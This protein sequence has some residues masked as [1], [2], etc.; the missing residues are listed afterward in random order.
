[1]HQLLP[2]S[3]EDTFES[4]ICDLFNELYNTRSFNKFGKKGNN[5]KGIDIYSCDKKIVVQCKK[6]DITRSK[7]SLKRELYND[8]ENDID[9]V[10]SKKMKIEFDSFIFTSTYSDNTDLIE[11]C[12]E[13][14]NDKNLKYSI[15]YWGW[16][17]LSEKA[18]KFPRIIKKDTY[19]LDCTKNKFN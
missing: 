16:E 9:S 1:M 14:A 15:D 3:N 17:T 18:L 10:N 6:K 4:F 13:L 2:L 11:F 5:Q 12:S 7:Q 19:I 8:I